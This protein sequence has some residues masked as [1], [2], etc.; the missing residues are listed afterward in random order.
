VD[1]LAAEKLMVR[2]RDGIVVLGRRVG[3]RRR[4]IARRRVGVVVK[5]EAVGSGLA[6]PAR[7]GTANEVSTEDS[8]LLVVGELVDGE[9]LA[10]EVVL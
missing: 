8:G 6:H 10:L 1:D 4:V 3:M 5:V 9:A 7:L 2:R